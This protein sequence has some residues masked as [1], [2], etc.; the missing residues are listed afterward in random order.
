MLISIGQLRNPAL[1]NLN[2][3]RFIYN[4]NLKKRIFIR[5]KLIMLNIST[6]TKCVHAVCVCVC[7]RIDLIKMENIDSSN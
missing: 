3:Y 2:L 7:Y 4:N 1:I 5:L 6:R